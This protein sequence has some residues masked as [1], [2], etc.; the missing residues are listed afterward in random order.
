M[1]TRSILILLLLLALLVPFYLLQKQLQRWLQPR[2]SLG[3]LMLY[4]LI[5]LTLVF[6]YTYL[7]VWLTGKLFPLA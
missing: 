5:M 7:L 6:G 2:L 4:L 3:R 1:N